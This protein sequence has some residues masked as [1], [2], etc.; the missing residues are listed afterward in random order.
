MK[1]M[2]YKIDP[3]D[4]M[5]EQEHG[6]I[7]SLK[8][9]LNGDRKK[10]DPKKFIKTISENEARLFETLYLQEPEDGTDESH[11]TKEFESTLTRLQKE[12]AKRQMQKLSADIKTAEKLGD[13]QT[14]KTLTAKFEQLKNILI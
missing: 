5:D 13:T 4:F 14:L 2:G 7:L 12:S 3:E 10:F 11:L 1:S 6:L 9:Y 8:K